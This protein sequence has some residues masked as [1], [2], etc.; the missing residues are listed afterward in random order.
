M[1]QW[2]TQIMEQYGYAGILFNCVRKYFSADP[3]GSDFDIWRLYDNRNGNANFWS[4]SF[5][6][7]GSTLGAIVLYGLGTVLD[8][9]RLG[10]IVERWGHLFRLTKKM[11]I[12]R[13][14][15]LIN[16]AY[17]RCF[18]PLHPAN[19]SLISIPAGMARMNFGMFIVLTAFGTFI[20]NAVLVNIG[21]AVGASWE[22]I[23]AVMEIYSTIIYIGLALF[24]LF[25]LSYGLI[26]EL[27]PNK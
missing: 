7:I 4:H 11:Y 18:L 1:Q 21:A 23:V 9:E 22:S 10:R 27:N 14:F 19:S 13:M 12:K 3:F 25:S 24:I 17:G 15:G 8:V 5:S 20:W 2:I 6:T 26:K 16:M